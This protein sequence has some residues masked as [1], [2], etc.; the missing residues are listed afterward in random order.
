MVFGN[1]GSSPHTRGARIIARIGMI[2]AGN[3]PRIR[4]E[5]GRGRRRDDGPPGI[6][7]AYAGSTAG[8]KFVRN[9]SE[10][11]SPHTRGAL[12]SSC[13]CRSRARDH[14]RIRGEHVWQH[15]RA[16][17]CHGIIPAY[18]GS[19]APLAV[20]IG[21]KLGSSPHTRGALAVSSMSVPRLGDHPRI[22]GE[23]RLL[24][25]RPAEE[26]GIIPAYAGST[27]P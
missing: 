21:V 26:A 23:H 25:H 2:C 20:T 16:L 5:H 8:E 4:G 22:R 24:D 6:I 15:R 17:L 12:R 1:V 10:G 18:A 3:H 19:T 14:P 27:T 11:S 13:A 7:P 9:R